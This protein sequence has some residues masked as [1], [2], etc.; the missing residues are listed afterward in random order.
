MEAVQIVEILRERDGRAR[1]GLGTSRAPMVATRQTCSAMQ[2]YF[3]AAQDDGQRWRCSS[4]A[5]TRGGSS[6]CEGSVVSAREL[7]IC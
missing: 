7:P 4:S 6:G 5:K 3:A 2:F 1:L